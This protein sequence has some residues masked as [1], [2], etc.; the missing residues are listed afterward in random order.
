[1]AFLHLQSNVAH[2]ITPDQET[3][4]YDFR[5]AFDEEVAKFLTSRLKDAEL[6]TKAVHVFTH[7]GL[8]IGAHQ[9]N[10]IVNTSRINDIQRINKFFEAANKALPLNGYL[11]GFVETIQTRKARILSRFPKPFSQLFYFIDFVL[12][13]FIPKWKVTQKAYF[14]LTHGKNRALTKTETL[15]RLVSC[16]FQICDHKDINGHTYFIAKKIN[17]PSYNLKPTYGTLVKM[18]RYG[19]DKKMIG[20]YKL[21]TMHPYSE[22]LQDYVYQNNNLQ[23]GGKFKD[24]FRITQWGKICRKLW[25]D[26]IPMFINVLKGEMKIVGVRPLSQ[27]YFDLYPEALQEKRTKYKPGLVPPYYADM[28]GTLKEI[29]DSEERYLDEYANKPFRTDVK[30]FYLAFKNILFKGARS[31]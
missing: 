25:L 26:E 28:P 23:D 13:R 16:G 18:N 11:I 15:G 12:N 9:P 24:D 3:Q 29:I 19:K 17:L 10:C 7:E 20:V 5:R 6:N 22:Y 31:N 4:E 21:R 27:H 30:Y 8:S 14:K 2:K 1:M